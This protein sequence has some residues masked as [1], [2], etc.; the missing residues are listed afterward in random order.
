VEIAV[1]TDR[2]D[3]GLPFDLP[4]GPDA[5]LLLHGLTGS[6]FEVR[7]LAE[8]LHGATNG[9]VRCLGPVL[10]G[11]A[12]GPR[13]LAGVTWREWVDGALAALRQLDGARRTLV[14]GCSM[15]ALA[16]LVLAHE[17]AARIDAL[18]LLA[19]ALRLSGPGHLAGLL[20]RLPGAG[21]L[22]LLPKGGSDVRDAAARAR[23]PAMKAIPISALG[24]LLAMQRHVD[25]ILPSVAA[26]ALVLAGGRDHTVTFG[27]VRRLADRLGPGGARLVVLPESFHLVGIDMERERA[28]DE[29]RDFFAAIPARGT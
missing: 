14:V 11:H 17:N 24:E 10:A 29:V 27:G 5:V 4:G 22:P 3:A 20:A 8:R 23:N 15:G 6:P 7:F 13:Q 2:A 16:A 19:P 26:P 21:L 12:G 1:S 9:A 18:A 28:A 25:R